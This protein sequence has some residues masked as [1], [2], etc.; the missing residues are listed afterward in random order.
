MRKT[1]VAAATAIATLLTPSSA[2][3]WGA[4]AHRY[5]M[6]RAID[7]LPAEI[8]PFFDEHRP[9]LVL[10]V[11][12]PDLWRVAG[13]DEE[14][15]NHFIDLGV[16]EYGPYPFVA[17][18]R[19]LDGA[20]EKFGL[21]TVR[22]EG[23]LPWRTMEEFGNL[24]R[25]ME[26]VGRHSLYADGNTV[27]FAAVLAHYV[28]DA[29]M[30]LHVHNNFDGQLT[31]QVGV[32]SRFE[33]ELFE[34]YSSRLTIKPET[35]APVTNV[36]DFIFEVILASHQLVPQLLEADKRAAAGRKTYDDEYFEKFFSDI[37]PLLEQQLGRSITATAAAIT[38]AWV[39]A[40]KPQLGASAR[41]IQ[42]VKA[43]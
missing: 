41:R 33:S 10:R 14:S 24:R 2:Y 39:G 35:P 29:H 19:D 36:R 5:I 28:Q 32:H 18:P 13:F 15:P 7:L 27:F 25:T 37:K 3:S 26:A 9:E 43:R 4:V 40:G 30:P 23:L 12:D 16:A 11:N 38:G 34:R 31:G 6:G 20:I 17:L 22:R 42:P 21:A 1:F 8:K